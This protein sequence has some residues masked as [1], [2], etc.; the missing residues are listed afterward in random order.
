MYCH[1][2]RDCREGLP[3][4]AD[5]SDSGASTALPWTMKLPTLSLLEEEE[6]NSQL[7][8]MKQHNPAN[9]EPMCMRSGLDSVAFEQQPRGCVGQYVH[10]I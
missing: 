6:S 7:T 8:G 3:E 5:A 4:R 1:T 2:D 9:Q 10:L